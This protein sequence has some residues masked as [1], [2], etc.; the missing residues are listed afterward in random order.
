MSRTKARFVDTSGASPGPLELW[1]AVI[2]TK[3][4]IDAE[5]ER[6]ASLPRP[7]NGRRQSVIAHPLATEPGLGLAPGI[8]VTLEVLLP[9]ERTERIR[10]NST[11]VNFCIRGRGHSVVEGKRIEFA[12]Y[13]VWNFPS[14]H[15][16]HHVNDSDDVQVRFSYSNAALLEKMNVHVVEEDPPPVAAIA[17]AE[18]SVRD[19]RRESPFGTFPLGDDGARM[20][21]YETLINPP[22][23][24]SKALHW[25]WKNFKRHLDELTALGKD[26]VGRRLYLCYNPRTAGTN[27]TTPNFFATICVRPA[28]IVDRPHRHVSAAINYYFAGSGRSTV[29]GEVFRWKAGDLMLSAPGWGVHNHASDDEPVYELTVQDQ[30]LHIATESLLWQEDLKK[31]LAVLGVEE[32]FD[33][34]RERATG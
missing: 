34:N 1:P 3:E 26:Y 20:M 22:S 19:P 12:Q 13:D 15:T 29:E 30:P 2:I 5:A 6:L 7:A 9:G 32:G 4:E 24:E 17:V 10:H 18:P 16:Y 14:W 23:V 27:G 28:G 25:P 8:R 11:Q 31:P 21:P 33:T